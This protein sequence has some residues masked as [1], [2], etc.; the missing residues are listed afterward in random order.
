MITQ[1]CADNVRL[2]IADMQLLRHD[3]TKEQFNKLRAS[4]IKRLEVTADMLEG[5]YSIEHNIPDPAPK[6]KASARRKINGS[7]APNVIPVDFK[8]R[9][10]ADAESVFRK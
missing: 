2:A 5:G 6:P 10:K 8:A 3:R 1:P 9:V 4:I 7:R